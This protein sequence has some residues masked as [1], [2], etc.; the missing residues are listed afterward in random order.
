MT[1]AAHTADHPRGPSAGQRT[2]RTHGFRPDIEGLRAVAIGLVLVY[3]AGL[4]WVPG[5][6]VGVDVFFVI[7]GFL[8]TT[9]LL[10]E[11]ESF[12]RI[13]LAAFYARRVRRL[14]PAAFL[15]LAGA[16]A[17]AWLFLPVT[18]RRVFGGDI[19]SSA[20]Y[21]VN[22]RLAARSVD[23]LAQGID[24][25]PVQHFWSLAVEEQ[26]YLIWPLLI[27]ASLLVV[28]RCHVRL[29]RAMGVALAV[30]GVPSLVWSIHETATNPS[31]AFFVTTT[32]LWELAVGAAV[33]V[34]AGLW[35]RIRRPLAIIIAMGG[36][37]AIAIAAL[38]LGSESS[39]PGYQALLPVLGAAAIIMAGF[40]CAGV[41]V[42]RL[43]SWRPFVWVGG[44]SYSLYL[45]HWVIITAA[46]AHYGTLGAG[47]G[48]LFAA[49]C[50][51]PAYL[52]HRLVENPIRYAARLRRSSALSLAV[53]AD[54][55]LAGAICGLV[56]MI[57]QI[58]VPTDGTAGAAVAP[59]AAV[60]ASDPQAAATLWQ[61]NTSAT[62]VP[63]PDAATADEP[64][65]Y[66][67]G[68]QVGG[69]DVKI[70]TY[71][72]TASAITVALV[73]DSKANQW[74]A[75]IEAIAE[76]RHWKLV[77]VLK[78]SCPFADGEILD[79]GKVFAA[80][81]TWNDAAVARVLAIHPQLVITSQNSS[82]S[83]PATSP[84]DASTQHQAMTAGLVSRWRTLQDAGIP[85][86]V[87][88]DNPGP[89]PG[90]VGERYECVA[91]HLNRLSTCAFPVLPTSV[92]V[93]TAAVQRAAALRLGGVGV[94]DL[95]ETICPGGYCP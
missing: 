1:A 71:G 74:F 54:L 62:I 45:W 56:L 51:I 33:A 5:G 73:G 9:M 35:I 27:V 23:Y 49:L 28:R 80:C 46:T 12:G 95:N 10:R 42:N 41:G 19:I 8:I 89:A 11:A 44:L 50:L 48:L 78:S 70:C 90:V 47:R 65:T 58:V 34:G 76:Q 57:P 83:V 22:W 21:V 60:V 81:D 64:A 14:L 3:H 86:A 94:I 75:A 2:A 38:L 68:C 61:Q 18:Q 7:S 32:R 43:L 87:I 36:I 55:S 20:G 30:V 24:A 84:G 26:F 92:E 59:G 85:V 25:S 52:S 79:L 72:D 31:V 82:L 77:T 4:T 39:W 40:T 13:S 93:Q 15:A 29:R 37:L 91:E 6:F 67:D 16:A 17:V 53:G 66:A 69:T 88:L 63:S